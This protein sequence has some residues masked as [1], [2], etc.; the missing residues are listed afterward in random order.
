MCNLLMCRINR[1]VNPWG[2]VRKLKQDRA[3]T[4][5]LLGQIRS[6][7]GCEDGD[8]IFKRINAL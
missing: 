3:D 4:T 8:N 7:L 2:Y 5:A 1:A 6:A